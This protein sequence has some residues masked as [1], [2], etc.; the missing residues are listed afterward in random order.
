[1]SNYGGGF[2]S[3]SDYDPR[4]PNYA[5]YTGPLKKIGTKHAPTAAEVQRQNV[6]RARAGLPLLPVP[7][8]PQVVG[9]VGGESSPMGAGAVPPG[10]VG[11]SVG[12]VGGD[13]DGSSWFV[14]SPGSDLGPDDLSGNGGLDLSTYGPA[15]PSGA[16]V[17][18]PPTTDGGFGG[19][20]VA[21]VG[22]AGNPTAGG[23]TGAGA[24]GAG[25][26]T[27]QLALIGLVG[28]GS[29]YL[30]VTHKGPFHRGRDARRRR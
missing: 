23:G 27:F 10:A 12:G 20:D 16:P 17:D 1:M 13:A 26:T 21:P 2:G 8:A 7:A 14:P 5:G 22:S 19:G 28:L 6:F 3:P 24:T 18:A 15:N 29:A 9:G 11:G 25:L 4:N 30:W